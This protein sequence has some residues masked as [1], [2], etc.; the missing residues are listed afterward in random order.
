MPLYPHLQ[1]QHALWLCQ[2]VLV[3]R[4]SATEGDDGNEAT[5][6]EQWIM[7]TATLTGTLTATTC[8]PGQLEDTDVDIYTSCDA[9]G[10]LA[11]S[12]DAYCGDVT[13]G[14]N[15][16]SEVTMDVVAGETY[17]FFWDDT[18]SPGPFTWYLYETPPPTD[19]T[20]LVAQ[21]GM[22]YAYLTWNGVEPLM[23][24]QS[25]NF[26]FNQTELQSQE[27]EY[28]NEKKANIGTPAP[29]NTTASFSIGDYSSNSPRDDHALDVTFL[30]DF[31][32]W[33]EEVGWSVVDANGVVV[34]SGI[35]PD[36]QNVT[37]LAE[38]T[39]T[40]L[41][42]DSYGDGWNGNTLF[43][44]TAVAGS[45]TLTHLRWSLPTGGGVGDD[46]ALVVVTG[47]DFMVSEELSD[48]SFSQ[49]AYNP[50]TDAFDV[51]ITNTG[52]QNAWTVAM[53]LDFNVEGAGTCDAPPAWGQFGFPQVAPAQEIVLELP[54][55]T[56][57]FMN[58]LNTG[59]GDF[60]VLAMVDANCTEFEVD[61]TNNVAETLVSLTDPFEGITWNVYRAEDG[62]E[63]TFN[64][65]ATAVD[66]Q[67]YLDDN[68][69]AGLP[70]GDYVYYV[71]QVAL[72]G[73]ESDPSNY[74]DASVFGA[75][76]FPPPVNL[77]GEADDF[78]VMLEWTAPDLTA[79]DPPVL[80]A[81]Y[82][83]IPAG[84]KPYITP[85]A[86]P[87]SS[88][89]Q[90]GDTFET[91]VAIDVLPY[92][93]TGTTVGYAADHGPYDDAIAAGLLCEYTGWAGNT[94]AAADVV[95]SLSLTEPTN[96]QISAC[97]SLYDTALG[98]FTMQEDG[99]G[100]MVPVLLAANDDFCGLQS[101]ITCEFPAGYIYIVI[102]GYNTSEGDY[103][104][105]VNNL[106]LESP[107]V[108]YGVYR[109]GEMV[110]MT[111]HVDSTSY[112]E[113]AYDPLTPQGAD[114]EYIVTA[115][116]G[117]FDIES[118]SAPVTVT[119]SLNIPPGD[120][121]LLAPENGSMVT[122]LTP[123]MMWEESTDPDDAPASIGPIITNVSSTK[124]TLATMLPRIPQTLV[125][126][127]AMM[128]I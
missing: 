111:D 117:D 45:D 55:V 50:V 42:T 19:P 92:E 76:D 40:V 121:S 116:Y 96:L 124:N 86:A 62:A 90:G 15:Y 77:I 17:Y 91:A 41:A 68:N 108:G 122:D 11:S 119:T 105:A 25:S 20:D 94:G 93:N 63:L 88:S 85:P 53:T 18:W 24:A 61:E 2:V 128:C 49:F 70:G 102:S 7:Y 57:Y 54:F 43:A 74:A 38:G 21:G 83:P 98:V 78:D 115:M 82:S 84:T 71:T 51:T 12:D 34:A 60:T 64:S 16:A 79:W 75:E 14:N 37:G 73:T 89:R 113:F 58:N 31:G 26:D 106:D 4:H 1:I 100:T 30:C 36:E 87:V 23:G 99:T 27:Q 3:I 109:D 22:G 48:L 59:Y 29:R 8:Y 67:E 56:D 101:E 72:D 9:A 114:H 46:G 13:G 28:Y 6:D 69:E 32:T 33:Q 112:H 35:A 5:G 127:R 125:I 65:V 66:A 81:N 47:P 118:P 52:L 104:L 10:P 107:V 120:F 126:L 95:Y 103:T 110:G 80:T 44:Y 39:Y 97:G 123:T